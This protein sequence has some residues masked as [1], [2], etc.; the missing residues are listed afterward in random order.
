M[1]A[2]SAKCSWATCSV[3]SATSLRDSGHDWSGNSSS[4]RPPPFPFFRQTPCADF[5]ST[6]QPPTRKSVGHIYGRQE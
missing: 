1:S 3:D 4:I 2:R 5:H 6:P